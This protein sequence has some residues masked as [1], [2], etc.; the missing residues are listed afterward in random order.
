MQSWLFTCRSANALTW[1]WRLLPDKRS[2]LYSASL[3]DISGSE[4]ATLSKLSRSINEVATFAPLRALKNF[5]AKQKSN[6]ADFNVAIIGVA[7]K[8]LPETDDLRFSTALDFIL[9]IQN[10]VGRIYWVDFAVTTGNS[11]ALNG[12]LRLDPAACIPE[13]LDAIFVLNNHPKNP[14]IKLDKWLHSGRPKLFFDGWGQ[15]KHLEFIEE[16]QSFNFM[17]MGILNV[18]TKNKR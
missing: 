5:A 16:I 9:E 15:F 18:M 11:H 12:C 4:A 10:K 7:F 6:I 2:L 8:G 14:E 17:C 13:D 3:S 1:C